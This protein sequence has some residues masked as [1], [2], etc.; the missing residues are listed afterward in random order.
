MTARPPR[1]AKAAMLTVAQAAGRLGVD[2][3]EVYHWIS[4]GLLPAVRYPTR[5]GGGGGPV[6]VAETD[7]DAFI[8]AHRRA[9]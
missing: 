1:A 7:V 9:S 4:A 8:A 5:N 6:R 3:R 2:P